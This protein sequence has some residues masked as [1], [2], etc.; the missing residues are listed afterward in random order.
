MGTILITLKL[1]ATTVKR[2]DDMGYGEAELV[3]SLNDHFYDNRICAL[4]YRLKQS[5]FATQLVDVNVDS[6]NPCWYLAVEVKMKRGKKALN[7]NSDFTTDI[8]GVH[9][10]TRLMEYA[11]VS[12]RKPIVYLLCRMGTGKKVLKYS[13]D[14]AKL[15][16]MYKDGIK[17]LKANQFEEYNIG[18]YDT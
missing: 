8:D 13:F 18:W 2:N 6:R 1:V 5:R 16:V 14:A 3:A 15:Y 17:S 9:Q 12:A 4:S 10:M 11:K 7:F